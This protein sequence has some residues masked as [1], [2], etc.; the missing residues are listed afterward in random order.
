MYNLYMDKLSFYIILPIMAVVSVL[1]IFIP[2]TV[3]ST[4]A[5]LQYKNPQSVEPSDLAF[6]IQRVVSVIVLGFVVYIF[7]TQILK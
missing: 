5:K 2:R 3:W 7:F 6:G 1:N 4:M